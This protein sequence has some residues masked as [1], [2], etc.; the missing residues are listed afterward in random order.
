MTLS[1]TISVKQS[2]CHEFQSI[3]KSVYLY[4][5]ITLGLRDLLII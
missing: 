1:V 5:I 4:R 2:C 3:K